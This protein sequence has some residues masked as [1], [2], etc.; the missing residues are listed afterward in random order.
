MAHHLAVGSSGEGYKA[1]VMAGAAADA[2]HLTKKGDDAA[3]ASQAL[4]APT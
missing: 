1:R 2:R 3:V 4:P